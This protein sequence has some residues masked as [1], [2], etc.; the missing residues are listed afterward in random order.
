[1]WLCGKIGEIGDYYG[2][3]SA[4]TGDGDEQVNFKAMT[5]VECYCSFLFVQSHC[6]FV[7]G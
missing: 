7:C 6:Y 5:P 3:D 4:L 2:C 1:M